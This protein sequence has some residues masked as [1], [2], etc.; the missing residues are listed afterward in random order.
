M[1]D[2]T[3]TPDATT[4]RTEIREWADEHEY[5]PVA[6]GDAYELRR[7]EELPEGETGG[8]WDEFL[9]TLDER[10]AALYRAGDGEAELLD[11]SAVA[12]RLNRP[13]DAVNRALDGGGTV[14][15]DPGSEREGTP[16]P[17]AA[18]GKE[19]RPAGQRN[20]G[21]GT[22]EEGQESAAGPASTT[23]ST[24]DEGARSE[25]MTEGGDAD[26]PAEDLADSTHRDEAKGTTA[27]GVERTEDAT[28]RETP[29]DDGSE[30]DEDESEAVAETGDDAKTGSDDVAGP[31]SAYSS[32]RGSSDAG[33]GA[34]LSSNDV[35]KGVFDGEGTEIGMV[36]AVDEETGEPGRFRVDP[37]PGLS[38]RLRGALGWGRDDE[39]DR[40]LDRSA[41]RR[42]EDDRV[43]VDAESLRD[44]DDRAT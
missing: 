33:A 38:D 27:G 2:D 29:P 22:P 19:S 5:V 7:R 1:N 3:R 32:D 16:D 9:A 11:R 30:G 41:V 17:N 39:A 6:R 10:D 42:V 44:A 14:T 37:D 35:G 12:A 28:V 40:V 26:V 21:A 43:V 15:S 25:H 34:N 20:T 8:D 24:E 4:D 18:V 13:L 31:E 23:R 36:A